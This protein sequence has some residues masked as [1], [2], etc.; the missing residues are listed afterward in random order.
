MP[1]TRRSF[2]PGDRIQVAHSA[3][4]WLHIVNLGSCKTA[5]LS[6]DGNEQVV[7][8]HFKGDWIGFDG[9][10]T[11]FC[12]SDA[13]AMDTGELWSLRYDLLLE[14]AA[15]Q[16][17][18]MQGVFAVMS[19]Q[20]TQ[21]RHRTRSRS[22]MPADARVADFVRSWADSLAE[23]NLRCDEI[24]LRMSR[25][26]IGSYL[27][28]TLETVSRALTRLARCG[29]IGL[30]ETRRRNITIPSAKALVDFVRQPGGYQQASDTDACRSVA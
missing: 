30:D 24:T 14:A 3:L 8:L 19:H 10:A 15:R 12:I 5:T 26:E 27:G 23:R 16:P 7:G 21:D 18:L 28:L 17:A 20:L 1:T 29:L 11:G 13:Y 2:L 6:A 9:I 4:N 25:A 22:L